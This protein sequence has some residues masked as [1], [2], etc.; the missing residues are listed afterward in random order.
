MKKFI[1]R[2]ILPVL[3]L[4]LCI[5]QVSGQSK[6]YEDV[7]REAMQDSVITEDERALLRSLQNS[8]GLS[9]N[10][11]LTIRKQVNTSDKGEQSV[12]H[13]GRGEVIAMSMAYGNGLYGWAIPYVLGADKT[14]I[15][16]GSEGLAAAAGFYYSWKK[17][18][19]MDIP[20][21]RALFLSAGSGVG[22]ASSVPLLFTVGG[23][24]W[25]DFDPDGKLLLTYAMMALPAG[26]YLGN[27]LYDSREPSDGLAGM[28]VSNLGYGGLNGFTA[29]A[30]LASHPK[31]IKNPEGYFRGAALT[32]YASALLGSY[33]TYRLF[34]DDHVYSGDAAFYNLGGT[35][36]LF[37]ASR[38]GEFFRVSGYKEV[39]SLITL[40]IDAGLYAAVRL[41]EDIDFTMGEVR[42]ISL[43]AMAG[44]ALTRGTSYLFDFDRSDVMP[45]LDLTATIGGGYTAYKYIAPETR[46]G[47]GN[48]GANFQ[49]APT[50]FAQRDKIFP[51]MAI[52]ATW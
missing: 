7:Y 33:Y 13:E 15:Y 19:T 21:G 31:D 41:N 46:K 18:K 26:V 17:T 52:Q 24:R 37:T 20:Q 16:V 6:T 34:K 48:Q 2:Y 51:G 12:S 32:T 45:L 25:F 43:G 38:L 23:E 50:F 28:T 1:D 30:L 11:I 42:I 27:H 36:G 40:S 49:V 29:F 35:A 22:L 47:R 14:R 10:Q 9:D 44:L 39:L 4:F 8:L 3:L 5:Q